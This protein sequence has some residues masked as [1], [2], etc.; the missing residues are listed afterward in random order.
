MSELTIRRLNPTEIEQIGFL[1]PEGWEDIKYY[2][3]FYS[4]NPFCYPIAAFNN[5]KIIG[6]G[7]GIVNKNSGWLGHIIVS[8][9]FQNQRI[10]YQLTENV[11]NY[12]KE[13]GC[14]TLFLFAT[15]MGEGLYK[16]FGFETECYYKF[17][18]GEILNTEFRDEHIRPAKEYDFEKI[19]RLDEEISG[20]QR[21]NM[22][23]RFNS[24]GWIY[25]NLETGEIEGYF[26]PEL[27]ER[28][29]I[30]NNNI[31]GLKL[32]ELKHTLKNC[33]TVLP[34]SNKEGQNFLKR[35][36]FKEYKSAPRMVLGQ[37]TNWNPE[38]IFSRIGG[39]YG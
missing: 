26:L 24:I 19:M 18:R 8:S 35:K 17:Y 3:K 21:K 32:L 25:E 12:L 11:I 36:G 39:F 15:E 7:N 10:G 9:D 4:Q 31:A 5:D 20:E 16:K 22:L 1:Q 14:K 6:V 29:I 38:M 28:L 37:K 27:G 13:Q 33:K 30:A 34:E 2:F 23:E